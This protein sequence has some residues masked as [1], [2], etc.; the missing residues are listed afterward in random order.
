MSKT[1]IHAFRHTFAQKYLLAGVNVFVFQ[2]LMMHSDLN[3]IKQ[4]LNLYLDDLRQDYDK[5]NPLD[6]IVK[7]GTKIKID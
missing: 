6:Q 4:Y 7:K 2:K 3:T 5:F 1:G